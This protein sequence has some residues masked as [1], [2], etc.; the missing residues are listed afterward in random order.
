MDVG[1]RDAAYS[2]DGGRLTNSFRYFDGRS[3]ISYIS[4]GSNERFLLCWNCSEPTLRKQVALRM[5]RV[6][7]GTYCSPSD[8][9]K[10]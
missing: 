4:L 3:T 1:L 2:L 10:H 7:M 6:Q 5:E 8:Q 9:R